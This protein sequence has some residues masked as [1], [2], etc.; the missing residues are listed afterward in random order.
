MNEWLKVCQ[1]ASGLPLHKCSYPFTYSTLMHGP[2]YSRHCPPLSS[3]YIFH[4]WGI[5]D[6]KVKMQLSTGLYFAGKNTGVGCLFLFFPTQGLNPCLLHFLHW[7]ADSL[8]LTVPPGKPYFLVGRN[9]IP[10]LFNNYVKSKP[11]LLSTVTKSSNN[12]N[13]K[14]STF[15][16]R[17]NFI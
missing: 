4:N 7:Q 5:N 14:L 8:P 12:Q 16:G 11:Q 9:E 2:L 13:V 17:L 15:L 6:L 1:T 10:I 3:S